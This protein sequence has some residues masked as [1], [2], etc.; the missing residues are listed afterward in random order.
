MKRASVCLG[1]LFAVVTITYAQDPP[2][3]TSNR[4]RPTAA[5]DNSSVSSSNSLQTQTQDHQATPAADNQG[6]E[7]S[8]RR[9]THVRLGG[10]V[11]SAGYS[12]F[13]SGAYPYGF[14]Y[15]PFYSPFS[16]ALWWDPFW[17]FPL[18]YPAGYFSPG[19]GKGEVKLGDAPKNASVY[20]NG[21]YAGTVEHLKSFWLDP[22]VYDLVLSSPDGREYQQRVYVLTGKTLK[23]EATLVKPT[24]GGERM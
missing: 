19:D 18:G 11:V 23:I 13:W 16:A 15:G 2:S 6:D 10:F 21:G 5:G 7:Q 14:P 4:P 24:T 1:I 12:H 20:L 3:K 17:G 9:E 22:G 8:S